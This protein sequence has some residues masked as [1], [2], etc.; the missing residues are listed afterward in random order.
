MDLWI[1]NIVRVHKQFHNV[2]FFKNLSI[3]IPLVFFS[4]LLF[5]FNSNV[6]AGLWRSGDFLSVCKH[7]SGCFG[8]S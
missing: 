1:L 5:N 8:L 6:L 7:V 4:E 2:M 3:P